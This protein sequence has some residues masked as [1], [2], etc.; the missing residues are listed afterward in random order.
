MDLY[1]L[2]I[3]FKYIAIFIGSFIEGITVGLMVGFLAKTH[4]INL[5]WGYSF[6]VLGDWGAD[7]VYY[8][9]GFFGSKKLLPKIIRAF[10]YSVDEVESL[11]ASFKKHSIKLI[12]LGKVTHVIGFPI[13]IAAGLSKFSWYR[14]MA[15]DFVAELIKAAIL[16]SIGYY[17]G[18]MWEEVNSIL[19]ILSGL[20]LVALV[21]QMTFIF[22]RR[23]MQI[24]DG[25]I[26]ISG[27]KGK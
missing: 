22:I 18:G 10:K 12:L 5:F 19:L 3:S 4:Y 23:H 16:I 14:F 6:H 13:I 24:K 27:K 17:F 2:I 21:G 8:W 15:L 26:I 25:D 9:L 11:E 20:G 1:S 7:I